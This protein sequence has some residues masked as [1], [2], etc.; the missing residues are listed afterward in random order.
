MCNVCCAGSVPRQEKRV[1]RAEIPA[2]KATPRAPV[3]TTVNASPSTQPVPS[4][5][6][7]PSAA[8]TPAAP[9][10]PAS[11]TATIPT[12]AQVRTCFFAVVADASSWWW[13]RLRIEGHEEVHWLAVGLS[14]LLSLF[15]SFQIFC[16]F[17]PS[18]NFPTTSPERSL[19]SQW[20]LRLWDLRVSPEETWQWLNV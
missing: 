2:P 4:S 13:D 15:P 11:A 9:S 19:P 16:L 1:E 18:L 5:R 3:Q 8:S 20:A 6:P 7:Q 10:T 14:L 12:P 17:F